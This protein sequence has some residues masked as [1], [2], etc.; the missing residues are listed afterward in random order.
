MVDGNTEV[1]FIF[2][3]AQQSYI[4]ALLP[5]YAKDGYTHYVIYTDTVSNSG[6]YTSANP[7]LYAVFSKTEITAEDGYNYNVEDDSICVSVRTAN[8]SAGSSA[9]NSD[10]VIVADYSAQVLTVPEY[11]H[12][13]TNATFEG[14]TLQPNY[15]LASRGETNVQI[16]TI[17]FILLIVCAFL[18]LRKLWVKRFCSI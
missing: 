13:Y 3:T 16:E 17:S 8:Y 15:Y 2:S 12:I 5:T 11:E 14:H 7:D 10:R 9:N 1:I 4:E 6:Y 18:V